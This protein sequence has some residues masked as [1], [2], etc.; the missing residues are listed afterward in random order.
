[1]LAK[2]AAAI[3]PHRHRSTVE[4][5]FKGMDLR[6]RLRTT[7]LIAISVEASLT[8]ES[9]AAVFVPTRSGA[10]ARQLARFRPFVWIVAVSSQES[11]CQALQ[12]SY[13]VH[14]V[15]EREHPEDW[16]SYARKWVENH[17]LEGRLVILT[18]GPSTKHPDA[19]HRMELIELKR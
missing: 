10:T 9:P 11:T 16:K 2:I 17:G 3:E 6:G 7:H 15:H 14:P 13:G 5:M 19:N 1:M 4:E 8:Y 18:E 12:F